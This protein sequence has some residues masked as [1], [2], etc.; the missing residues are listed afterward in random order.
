[1]GRKIA[2]EHMMMCCEA[3]LKI[4][5]IN[6]EVTG[7]QWEFQIGPL[8]AFDVS[9]QL[10]IARYIL[11]KIAEKYD[12]IITFH[13]KPFRNFNGSGAHTNFSTKEMREYNGITKIYEAIEKLSKTHKEHIDVYGKYNEQRLIGT[14]ETANI[15]LFSFGNC[16]HSSSIR[17]PLNVL[18]DGRGYLED[19][20]PAS[21][22]DPYLVIEQ[23]LKTVFE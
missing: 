8:N 16:V 4:C 20:R 22:M 2:E 23:I 6:S 19:R 1:M 12:A 15:N 7:S 10:W 9:N 14:N 13:P 21:N 5:G 17:I 18:K 11:I 3:G